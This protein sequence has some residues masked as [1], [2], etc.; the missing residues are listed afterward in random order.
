MKKALFT[1]FVVGFIASISFAEE[2]LVSSNATKSEAPGNAAV[3]STKSTGS[4]TSA[5]P[6]GTINFTGKVDSVSSG[7][8]M[9]V[10]SQ[11]I[12]KDDSGKTMTFIVASDANIIG[13]DGNLTTLEWISKD[14]KVAIEYTTGEKGIGTAKSIKV[15]SSW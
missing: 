7:N 11:I 10:S 12:V 2:V 14:D 15:L 13:K 3:S 5:A 9:G 1:L 4:T 8:S 6:V